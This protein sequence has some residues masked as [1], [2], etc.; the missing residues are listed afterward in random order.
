[1]A[2]KAAMAK[3]KHTAMS[4]TNPSTNGGRQGTHGTA[5]NA[6]HGSN[7]VKSNASGSAMSTSKNPSA[8]GGNQG[9]VH[10]SA[11][12]GTTS[13]TVNTNPNTNLN[14]GPNSNGH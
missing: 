9:S 2:M 6:G 13:G 1:M 3:K 12:A 10:N 4:S 7:V 11:G 14:A 5:M 8:N